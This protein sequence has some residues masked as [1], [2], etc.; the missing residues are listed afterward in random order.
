MNMELFSSTGAKKLRD[1]SAQRGSITLAS[2]DR[3]SVVEAEG[4][5]DRDS[6]RCR[7]VHVT[8]FSVL[9]EH[10]FEQPSANH[11]FVTIELL[12]A[13]AELV[14]RTSSSSVQ[15]TAV[16]VNTNDA[17]LSFEL[18]LDDAACETSDVIFNRE[19]HRRPHV[20]T[21]NVRGAVVTVDR[22]FFKLE[23]WQSHSR[24]L[25]RQIARVG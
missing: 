22:D 12:E 2:V 6:F 23:L 8:E 5:G 20:L 3:A 10:A 19:A 15:P 11:A 16:K 4:Q 9:D 1:V 14:V 24:R 13:N 17:L 7:V 18:A 21:S 25:H